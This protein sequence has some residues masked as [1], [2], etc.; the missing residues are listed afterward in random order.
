MRSGEFTSPISQDPDTCMVSV[1]DAAVESRQTPQILTVLIHQSKTD[2]SGAGTHLY[3]GWTGNILCPVSAVLAYLA[4]RPPIPGPLFLFQNGTLL[5]RDWLV[6]HMRE[7]LYQLGIDAM[8]IIQATVFE[9][10]RQ[11]QQ[12][13]LASTIPLFKHWEGGSQMHSQHISKHQLKM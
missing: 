12:Q 10:E 2:Q 7:A 5:S 4:I 3:L 9:F 1:V 8:N 6:A 11:Q 13:K